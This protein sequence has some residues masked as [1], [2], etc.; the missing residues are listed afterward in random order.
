MEEPVKNEGAPPAADPPRE[1]NQ[2][3]DDGNLGK[4]SKEEHNG[5]PEMNKGNESSNGDV[6][7]SAAM[8]PVF[9]GN[10]HHTYTAEDVQAIFDRPILPDSADPTKYS[11]VPVERVDMK[12]GYCFVFLKDARNQAEKDMALRFVEIINGM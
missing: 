11:P 2:Q 9:L 1:E 10:L 7:G 5:E 3:P 12:R 8:R 4:E 6:I